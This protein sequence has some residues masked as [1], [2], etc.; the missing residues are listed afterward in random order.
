MIWVII[1]V[2]LVVA[3]IIVNSAYQ[4]YMKIVG[5][6]GMFFDPKKKRFATIL[7]ALFICSSIMKLFGIEFP[8]K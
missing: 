8:G 3:N 7:I 2:S 5:A 4:L 1:V 6:S